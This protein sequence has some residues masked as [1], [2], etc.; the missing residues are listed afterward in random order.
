MA[1]C[2]QWDQPLSYFLQIVEVT[3]DDFC[4]RLI[5]DEVVRTHRKFVIN[6]TNNDQQVHE[7]IKIRKLKEI[8]DKII[9]IEDDH[10][11]TYHLVLCD[12]WNTDHIIPN[13]NKIT[14]SVLTESEFPKNN[15]NYIPNP[16]D[17]STIIKVKDEENDK[18]KIYWSTPSNLFGKISYRILVNDEEKAQTAIET[19]PYSFPLS[20]IP[21]SFRVITIT[22]IEDLVQYESDPS[23]MVTIGIAPQEEEKKMEGMS[24]MPLS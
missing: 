24:A 2:Q 4:I 3:E 10:D 6:V 23:E 14:F 1:T 22:S 13:T 7:S 9:F 19:L 20:S 11:N 16:I 8:E 5:A 21:V 15:R 17:I 18:V 12:P